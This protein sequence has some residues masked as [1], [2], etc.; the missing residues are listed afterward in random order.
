MRNMPNSGIAG[1]GCFCAGGERPIQ[2]LRGIL[3]QQHYGSQGNAY[4]VYAHIYPESFLLLKII[5]RREQCY[6]Q[7]YHHPQQK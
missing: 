2:D 5:M 7:K 6:Q 1:Y 3:H 4:A